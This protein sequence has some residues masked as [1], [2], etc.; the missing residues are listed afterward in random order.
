MDLK[1][2]IK[3]RIFENLTETQKYTLLLLSANNFEPI[4]GKLWYQKELFLLSKNN[5]GLVEDADFEP[6]FMG[7]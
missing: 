2:D 1:M 5:E 6:D 4:K 7:R 3:K